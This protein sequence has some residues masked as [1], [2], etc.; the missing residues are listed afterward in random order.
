MI[1]LRMP[2]AI[3]ENPTNGLKEKNEFFC[4][5]F[6]LVYS[7]LYLFHKAGRCSDFIEQFIH[8]DSLFLP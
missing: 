5:G 7:R 6:N 1:I 4:I 8:K 2:A 3:I